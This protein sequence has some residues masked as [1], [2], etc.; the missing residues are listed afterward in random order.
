MANSQLL[1][2]FG[3]TQEEKNQFYSTKL[4]QPCHLK[5]VRK[6]KPFFSLK[7]FVIQLFLHVL[8]LKSIR[9]VLAIICNVR[10][11]LLV[12]QPFLLNAAL[13]QAYTGKYTGNECQRGRCFSEATMRRTASEVRHLI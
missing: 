6:V 8:M 1:D 13:L 10:F 7:K 3:H 5:F 11:Q 2:H 12:F 9:L 4:F